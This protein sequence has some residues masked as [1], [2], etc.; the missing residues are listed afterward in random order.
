MSSSG[1]VFA[2]ALFVNFDR[3]DC[4][5]LSL[6]FDF[7]IRDEEEGFSKFLLVQFDHRID[8]DIKNSTS[9]TPTELLLLLLIF[10]SFELFKLAS[11]AELFEILLL[12]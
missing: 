8:Q 11:N 7:L 6:V 12:C 10:T 2:L 4:E 3:L 9:P 5:R 1:T